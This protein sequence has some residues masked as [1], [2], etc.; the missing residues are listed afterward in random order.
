MC[1]MTRRED[2]EQAAQLGVDAVGLIFYPKS[3]RYLTLVKAK[4]LL[5]DLPPFMDIVAV[6]VNPE[7]DFVNQLLEELPVHLLQFHGDESPEFCQQFN[8]P[9]IKTIHPDSEHQILE[10]SRQF[11][12]A[13]SLLLDTLLPGSRGG[14]G[15]VFNWQLIPEA[16]SKNYILAG[17]LNEFNVLQAIAACHP[18][19]IDVC[20]GIEALPGIKDPTKMNRFI[21]VLAQV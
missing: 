20:S 17:G 4:A 10:A 3:A 12:S 7:V 9:Y 13:Q 14:T 8:R 21:S 5:K 6:L 15:T 1:G 2:I 11:K 19:A 18:K 16:L